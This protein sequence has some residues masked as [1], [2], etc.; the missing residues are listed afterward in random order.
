MAADFDTCSPERFVSDFA[1]AQM[2][3]RTGISS[4]EGSN[5]LQE[6]Q[7]LIYD[8]LATRQLRD[9]IADQ[10][11]LFINT[12]IPD[13]VRH[14]LQLLEPTPEMMD[15]IVS[16]FTA[17]F[18][19]CIWGI[20][21][22]K[23]SLYGL[24][25]QILSP[26]QPLFRNAPDAANLIRDNFICL[27]SV[28]EILDLVDEE[29]D[30]AVIEIAVDLVPI[31]YRSQDQQ[32]AGDCFQRVGQA[33]GR[34][35]SRICEK[36][37]RDFEVTSVLGKV[38]DLFCKVPSS[39]EFDLTQIFR[40]FEFCVRSEILS[41]QLFVLQMIR[42]FLDVADE[43]QVLVFKSWAESTHFVDYLLTKQFP[44]QVLE[45]L[46]HILIVFSSKNLLPENVLDV[47]WV[48]SQKAHPSQKSLIHQWLLRLMLLRPELHLFLSELLKDPGSNELFGFLVLVLKARI[49]GTGTEIAN[50]LWEKAHLEAAALDALI[51]AA[52]S[53]ID[54]TIKDLFL[55]KCF[56]ELRT[57]QDHSVIGKVLPHLVHSISEQ[58]L[59][60]AVQ[61]DRPLIVPI[62]GTSLRRLNRPVE[63]DLIVKLAE[64]ADSP[65]WVLFKS[66]LD[67]QG[68]EATTDDG[69]AE[70]V[71]LVEKADFSAASLDFCRFLT[72]LVLVE[73]YRKG[74]IGPKQTR[75]VPRPFK[76]SLF[77]LFGTNFLFQAL[78]KTESPQIV[79]LVHQFLIP[80]TTSYSLVPFAQVNQLIETQFL[81]VFNGDSAPRYK[82]R[83]LRTLLAIVQFVER[84][85]F[86]EDFGFLRHGLINRIKVRILTKD[87]KDVLF[88]RP[89]DT[90]ADLRTR[91][92]AAFDAPQGLNIFHESTLLNNTQ[93]MEAFPVDKDGFIKLFYGYGSDK[94]ELKKLSEF[95]SLYLWD[96]NFV[97][98]LL[99]FADDDRETSWTFLRFLP[100]TAS[101][102]EQVKTNFDEMISRSRCE[103][104]YLLEM[105]VKF[106][107]T[108][109]IKNPNVAKLA[110]LYLAALDDDEMLLQLLLVSDL[111]L[112]E[113]LADRYEE[114]INA[115]SLLLHRAFS[116]LKLMAAQFLLK[117]IRKRPETTVFAERLERV[118]GLIENVDDR[119]WPHLLNC[120]A[121]AQTS[122]PIFDWILARVSE[123]NEYIAEL[124]VAL[125]PKMGDSVDVSHVFPKCIDLII[126]EGRTMAVVC[127]V[128]G[129]VLERG[130]VE[131]EPKLLDDLLEIAFHSSDSKTRENLFHLC[132]LIA[133]RLPNGFDKVA[134]FLNGVFDV[135]YDF[136]NRDAHDGVKKEDVPFLGLT[137][138]G[139]TCYM[140]ATIQQL[141]HTVQFRNRILKTEFDKEPLKRF[142]EIFGELALSLKPQVETKAFCD[143]WTGYGTR[144]INV[145]E[146]QDAIEFLNC[147]LERL[148]ESCSS[149]FKGMFLNTVRGIYQNYE[150]THSEPFL[151]IP[152]DVKTCG[153]I[154]ESLKLLLECELFTDEDRYQTDESR[155][156]D[157]QKF[158]RIQT[159]PEVLIFQLK[160]FEYDI[161]SLDRHKVHSYFAF[162]DDLDISLLMS[163]PTEDAKFTLKGVVSHAGSAHGGHYISLIRNKEQWFRISDQVVEELPDFESQAFGGHHDCF[164]AYLLFYQRVGVNE[165]VGGALPLLE[166]SNKESNRVL[167]RT[168]ALFS[169]ETLAFLSCCASPQVV[170]KYIVNILMRSSLSGGIR[171]FVS[172]VVRVT[173]SSRD[174]TC[175]YL[176]EHRQ[177]V[178][179]TMK[180]CNSMDICQGMLT[181]I[182]ALVP[183]PTYPDRLFETLDLLMQQMANSCHFVVIAPLYVEFIKHWG[184][185]LSEEVRKSWRERVTAW[186]MKTLR[187]HGTA[188]FG[189]L[190][191]V[192]TLV[193]D[194]ESPVTKEL[195]LYPANELHSF[196]FFLLKTKQPVEFKALT[197]RYRHLS[198][199]EFS[200][201]SF[202][203]FV[204]FCLSETE[205]DIADGLVTSY[206]H[207]KAGDL[208][209]CFHSELRN[210][211]SK[212]RAALLREFPRLILPILTEYQMA[213]ATAR[214]FV[215]LKLLP[216]ELSYIAE[217][218]ASFTPSFL[219]VVEAFYLEQSRAWAHYE[220]FLKCFATAVPHSKSS[221]VFE[222]VKDIVTK[223]GSYRLEDA[224]L[225]PISALVCALPTDPAVVELVSALFDWIECWQSPPTESIV[226]LTTHVV[227]FPNCGAALSSPAVLKYITQGLE[228][229]WRNEHPLR[230]LKFIPS[231]L[232]CFPN[233]FDATINH[234]PKQFLLLLEGFRPA[235]TA[236]RIAKAVRYIAQCA[237]GYDPAVTEL[238]QFFIDYFEDHDPTVLAEIDV[239]QED[240]KRLAKGLAGHFVEFLLLFA[241]HNEVLRVAV[242]NW[243]MEPIREKVHTS[244]GVNLD[245]GP[246][247]FKFLYK[248]PEGPLS[249]VIEAIGARQCYGD[250]FFEPFRKFLD[251]CG[252]VPDWLWAKAKTA[253]FKRCD[254]GRESCLTTIRGIIL[255]RI[256]DESVQPVLDEQLRALLAT[257]LNSSEYPMAIACIADIV[258]IRPHLAGAVVARLPFSQDSTRYFYG[259]T[260]TDAMAI[261]AAA[262]KS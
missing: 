193:E 111:F 139:A 47:L 30:A 5:V 72:S 90:V 3:L 215:E 2:V 239:R 228:D 55:V 77:P 126:S 6:A 246:L 248:E 220:P 123:S 33:L 186:I 35:L 129:S 125:V 191:E 208:I 240:V 82:R 64:E 34:L 142:Q 103:R 182:K 143:V 100:E 206:Q 83:C 37:E 211:N 165:A 221:A 18:S 199:K 172:H 120:F 247:L 43:S 39:A 121:L 63:K 54:G 132:Q 38:F 203:K 253:L 32:L 249:E 75:L 153:Q 197:S 236:E 189:P 65:V 8:I 122:P 27:G 20:R 152:L 210:G 17:V 130:Q 87:R 150:S 260:Y 81:P 56:E 205:F 113:A 237:F 230:L 61:F 173:A 11:A 257:S 140:N 195:Y 170:M 169:A 93:K 134:D 225:K 51:S 254:S 59:F 168:Q 99:T 98:F 174:W 79:Q 243:C 160:R 128:A 224:H 222:A 214:L 12:T 50:Y 231:K 187:N 234:T 196:F 194:A 14:L 261:F 138:L 135:A 66:L 235:L 108:G 147:F 245:M 149:V 262:K 131:L 259:R 233:A 4:C 22:R 92:C 16:F 256:P 258:R 218:F 48:R 107:K 207:L 226:A 217:H 164:S 74:L 110:D 127:T 178:I 223:F 86:L 190:L 70:F 251:E 97:D 179:D 188:H 57:A 36:K 68:I 95:P 29:P 124:F 112:S 176:H 167:A 244:W 19:L 156:I 28:N 1:S 114:L 46:G 52:R 204:V 15:A 42:R 238:C 71:R 157:A 177:L 255:E 242:I 198:Y 31:I 96:H 133:T 232:E 213:D 40:F 162:P 151:S 23:P 201:D 76:C 141:F 80:L 119:T 89:Q 84:G 158:T 209:D 41:R 180:N 146:Q 216:D 175:E 161:R 116:E 109:E 78:E 115:T 219:A 144:P 45:Q 10:T 101:H 202:L 212:L 185:Q 13:A 137:N 106:V 181:I 227:I 62:I 25:D 163:E 7:E 229:R 49:Q 91:I 250:A 69:F 88:M 85:Y 102:Q 67:S 94:I 136:W 24:I 44:D 159:L 252:G 155:K 166:Q 241:R 73:N 200:G 154:E 9:P 53:E 145:C 183:G 148:P 105:F 26:S 184:S 104:V 21:E 60:D 171:N 192:L 58:Q 117:L 118:Q